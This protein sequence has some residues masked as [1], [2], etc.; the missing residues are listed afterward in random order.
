MRDVLPYLLAATLFLGG[1]MHLGEQIGEHL[2]RALEDAL[3][4]I[5]G[6]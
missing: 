4:Q 1:A 2:N 3:A 6:P 5:Q